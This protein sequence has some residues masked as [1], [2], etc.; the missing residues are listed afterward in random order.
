MIELVQSRMADGTATSYTSFW[1]ING[2]EVT[3]TSTVIDELAQMKVVEKIVLNE[4]VA[5]PS[6]PPAGYMNPPAA[7]ALQSGAPEPNIALVNAPAL[8]NQG[9]LG[10]GVVVANMDTGVDIS[11]P[12][13]AGKWRGGANSWFDPYGQH[14]TPTDYAGAASGHGTW[15]M[16]II[17]GGDAGGTTV[18]MAPNAQWIAAKIF[19]DQGSGTVAGI[20]AAFQWL[21]DPDGDP[22]TDDTPHVV[23]GSWT[24]QSP[25][26]NLEFENDIAVLRTAGVLPIFAA[27]NGGPNAN[28]SYSPAN[29]PSAFAVG[30]VDNADQ[31]YAGGSRG[32]ATCGGPTTI[33]PH[34]VAPGVN[35]KTTDLYG[36]YFGQ[37]G[38]SL[39]A[40]HASGALA[41]L[42]NAYPSATAAQQQAALLNA[43]VDLGVAGADNN[44]GY[45]R[46]D[47]L[48][49]YNWLLTNGNNQEPTVSA[50]VDV[51]V[52]L[53]SGVTLAG[54]AT[55]DG[56][57]APANLVTTWTLQSGSGAVTFGNVN[58]AQTSAAFAVEGLYT[59]RLTA[60]DGQLSV[61]D[62]ILVTVLS[63]APANQAPTVNA[64]ADM[65]IA[66]P[67]SA[68]LDGSA[69]DDGLPAPA[70]LLTTWSVISGPGT[71]TFDN[72]NARNATASFA[73]DGVYTLRL[74]A[75]DG[76]LSSSD[77]LVI[78]VSPA[79]ASEAPIY[80]SSTSDGAVGGVSFADEDIL[81]YDPVTD[82]WALAF[83]GSDVELGGVDINAFAIL[84]DGSLL[85]SPDNPVIISGIGTVDDSDILHF[86]PTSLGDNTAGAYELYFRGADVGLTTNGEDIVAI[87]FA[88][89]GRL[90]IS[91]LNGVSVPGAAGADEDLLA[92]APTAL[93]VPTSGAWS[94]YFDGSTAELTDKAEEVWGLSI[95]ASGKIYLSTKANFNVSGV[96]GTAAD[97][98]TC[99]P[100]SL[101]ANNTSCTYASY[102]Q[103]AN[104]GFGAESI[105][106]MHIGG[107]LSVSG[108][109][110]N[111][112]PTVN[113]GGDQSITLP[114]DATLSGSASDD[115]LPAPANLVTTWS[116]VSGPGAVTFGNTNALNTTASFAVDGVYTLRLTADDGA[117]SAADDVIISVNAAAGSSDVIYLSSSSNGTVGGVAFRDEDIV[118]Y[119]PNTDSWSLFF[120]GSD[121][122]LGGVDINAFVI[123]SDGSL[124]L[125]TDNP[126][127]ISGIGTVDDSDI[128]HFMPTALGDNTA[129]SYELY[130]VGAD[131]GLTTNGED[132]VAIDF[133][134]DGRL[135]ISTLNSASVAGVT[136]RDEDLLAFAPTALGVPT[137]GSWS[138]YFDGS[139]AELADATEE[140]WGLSVDAS[141]QIFLSTKDLFNVSGASGTAADI[142]TCTPLALGENNTS[143]TYNIYWTGADHGFGGEMIDALNVGG[144]PIAAGANAAS[145]AVGAEQPIEADGAD[146]PTNGDWDETAA[147]PN[148]ANAGV[149]IGPRLYLP[150]VEVKR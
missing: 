37:T 14:A 62:T 19:N 57:P 8:W 116:V 136:A 46:L 53:A 38:T 109:P 32:P 97:I 92:F 68:L 103:G 123:L 61:G 24:F 84:D 48:S 146:D 33:F 7:H 124:L 134:P 23:N 90:L 30:A 31:I 144:T 15:S 39:A 145:V 75:D 72:A 45:G 73:V 141:G 132:I 131:V 86:T 11:H 149:V 143:C 88:P 3:A 98:F 35:V 94:L 55:D 28:T 16:G 34:M 139:T 77:D 150:I 80:L 59:L 44:F 69:S 125:S 130:F 63:G 106:G 147:V 91:T 21:L 105:D 100:I 112:A 121:V 122:E 81:M 140:I 58:A 108:D 20:H 10:Q 95:D 27:G 50:G 49:A 40:P 18:G 129:G 5:A 89:D 113:A 107:V 47:V 2:L 76:E 17:V 126:V 54:T 87:D 9:I 119:D 12:D 78:N 25:G 128:L 60:N 148:A 74:T 29:N 26:C 13:L 93:G 22:N 1:M 110:T 102:W 42:L 135:L 114:G 96:T 67:D 118:A 71:V 85:L 51:T 142:F 41:L 133:A 138:L 36:L 120:D 127:T 64:G 101:G 111:Q 56:L 83:D 70:N 65:A 79:T 6:A 52:T 66:L 99:T 104:H 115:G 82:H 43:S 4:P 117:L 137:S